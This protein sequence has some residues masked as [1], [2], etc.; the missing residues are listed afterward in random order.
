VI[1]KS[2]HDA[3]RCIFGGCGLRPFVS[4]YLH[5]Q[6]VTIWTLYAPTLSEIDRASSSVYLRDLLGLGGGLAFDKIAPRIL[7]DPWQSKP[8]LALCSTVRWKK[9]FNSE[10]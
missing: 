10:L 1:A 8:K 3:E 6:P 9:A 5:Y 2:R 4:S 7:K